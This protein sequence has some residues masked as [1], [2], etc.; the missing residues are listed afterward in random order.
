MLPPAILNP[1]VASYVD[2]HD[3]NSIVSDFPECAL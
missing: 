1:V 3:A 2:E